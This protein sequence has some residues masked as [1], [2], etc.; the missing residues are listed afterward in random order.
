M[1]FDGVDFYGATAG[2]DMH[3]VCRASLD[4]VA[5]TMFGRPVRLSSDEAPYVALQFHSNELLTLAQANFA[6]L[7][8]CGTYSPLPCP[9]AMT[10]YS[11]GITKSLSDELNT[12]LFDAKV[13]GTVAKFFVDKG[14]TQREACADFAETKTGIVDIGPRSRPRS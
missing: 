9:M 1:S 5:A 14:I 13:P 4:E 8:L 11:N 3:A 2:T 10:N 12:C 7:T 6:G